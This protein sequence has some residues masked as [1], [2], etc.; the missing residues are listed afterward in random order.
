MDLVD[1]SQEVFENIKDEFEAFVS[2]LNIPDVRYL[3]VSAL[4]GDN[5]VHRSEHL[6]W[7][8]GPTLL[9]TLEN[10]HAGSDYNMVDA[11]FPVQYVIRPQK[12]EFHDFRGYAGRVEGGVFKPGDEIM[13]L[14]IGS[15]L[16][17]KVYR[18]HGR[19]DGRSF[20]ATLCYHD[21]RR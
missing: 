11:R 7:F 13:A 16:Q 17:N 10:I 8:E 3:P 12:T 20:S 4:D 9:Y 21:T 2:K 5:V 15:Y 19:A 14:P 1:Y 18:T 6:K